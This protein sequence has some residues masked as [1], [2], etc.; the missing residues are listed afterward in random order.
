MP[1]P[2][3]RVPSRVAPSSPPPEKIT[4]K[5]PSPPAI[6]EIGGSGVFVWDTALIDRVAA[7]SPTFIV[8][9]EDYTKKMAAI[10]L[11][12]FKPTDTLEGMLAASAIALH[13]ASLDCSRRAILEGQP[14]EVAS[15]LR[16]DAVNS[17]RGMLDVVDALAR[18]RGKSPQVI[19]V[20]KMVVADGG[21]AVLGNVTSGASLPTSGPARQA[22]GQGS[23]PMTNVGT[24]ASLEG[25]GVRSDASDE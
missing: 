18:Y 19:R 23:D 15:R 2:T 6:K 22:I 13:H 16:R 3:K 17:A 4:N 24:G 8:D 12:A 10:A 11:R 25:V 14:S 9:G 1:A 20:E 7:T 21:A 5:T